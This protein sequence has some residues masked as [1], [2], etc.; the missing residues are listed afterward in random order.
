MGKKWDNTGIAYNVEL[1]KECLRVLKPG[2]HLLAFGGTRTYHRMAVAIEDAGFEVRDM[3]EWIYSCLSIDTEVLTERGYKHL[4]KL[5]QYDRIMVYDIQKD[6]YKWEKPTRWNIYQVNNDTA[7]HIQSDYTDQIVSKNHNCIVEREGKLVFLQAEELNE[8]EYM[9]TLPSDFY[10]LQTIKGKLLFKTVLWKGK[11]LVKTLL[12]K[13]KGQKVSSEGIKN[14]KK[15]CL[16]RWSN[17]FQKTRK[18][19]TNKVCSVS[20][21]IFEDGTKRRLCDGTSFDYGSLNSALPVEDR[22]G[23]SYQ[24]RPAEQPLGEFNAFQDQQGTQIIRRENAKITKIKYSG[25]IFCPT[26]STGAFVARRNGKI[27]ITG[28]SGFPKSLS[29][30]K[31]VDKRANDN[32]KVIQAKKNLGLWLKEKRGD[33]PQKEVAKHFLSKTGGLTGCVANWELGFN[34]PTWE[35]WIKLKEILSLDERYDYLIEGRPNNFIPDER[36]VL[37]EEKEPLRQGGTVNWD[38][39]SS[40]DRK[41]TKGNSEWEGFGTALKPSHEPVI[42]ASKRL[43]PVPDRSK[44]EAGLLLN[45]LLCQTLNVKFA[46]KFLELNRQEQTQDF[47]QW[48]VSEWNTLRNVEK[49]EKTG[50]FKSREMEKIFWNIVGLWSNILEEDYLK[51]NN[52]TTST[53][54]SKIIDWKTLKSLLL[55]V[56]YPN[57]TQAKE[58]I[59]N[60]QKQNAWSVENYLKEELKNWKPILIV[61]AEENV[62]KEMLLKSQDELVY[63]AE[64]FIDTLTLKENIAQLLATTNP[65]SKVSHEPII[66]AR[67]P[68][69]EKTIVENVLKHGTGAIDIDGT[70]IPINSEDME[71]AYRK[72]LEKEREGFNHSPKPEYNPTQ[73]RFPANIICTDDALNDGVMTK[74]GGGKTTRKNEGATFDFG[75]GYSRDEISDSGSKSRYFDID[76]WGEKHGL[77]QF[78]KASRKDRGEGNTHCTCKPTHLMS[79]LVR[80]VSKEGDIVLDPFMGSGTTGVACKKLGRNFIGIELN[81][82]Y[83]SIAN[84]RINNCKVLPFIRTSSQILNEEYCQIATARTSKEEAPRQEL[85]F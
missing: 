30:G 45:L 67:K 15:S 6:I 37:R 42:W 73:G 69:S 60:G 81:Q 58:F 18:L 9:P 16:E 4:H 40:Q 56:I 11:G 35:I 84:A 22:S 19:Q 36:E 70:R 23:A 71:S 61:F 29:I 59:V 75:Q 25:L 63:F 74:S 7:Y 55:A 41:L 39:R 12:R 46:E 82:E 85:L 27:F 44:I 78:P 49:L 10:T 54:T 17:L 51:Q 76:V 79:W 52:S 14:G 64:R 8:M 26:V 62:L 72:P 24:S 80:L 47:V 43:T 48:I 2:G 68:L 21:A 83:I 28:N 13:W 38:M 53:E 57:I 77:L 31:A 33:M 5:T 66:M 32:L 3:L 65:A 1:W 34:L 20:E 50:I